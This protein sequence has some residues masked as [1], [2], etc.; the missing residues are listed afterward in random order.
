MVNEDK[1]QAWVLDQLAKSEL[2]HQ[3]LHEWEMLEIADKI[4]EAKGETWEWNLQN[5]GIS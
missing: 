2:F 3:K 4:E 5:L 1:R